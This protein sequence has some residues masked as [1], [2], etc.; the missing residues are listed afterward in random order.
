[1]KA[2]IAKL[3]RKSDNSVQKTAIVFANTREVAYDD[4][5]YQ[6]LSA[7]EKSAIFDWKMDL[8]ITEVNPKQVYIIK[9]A[10]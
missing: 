6:A 3:V 8:V 7:H 1:M 10:A 5:Y 9:E 2:W 4:V